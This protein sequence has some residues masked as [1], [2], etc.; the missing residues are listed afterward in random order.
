MQKGT[1]IERIEHNRHNSRHALIDDAGQPRGPA[2]LRGASDNELLRRRRVRELR[3]GGL[4]NVH[5]LDRR[6]GHRQLQDPLGLR[7]DWILHEMPPGE[8]DRAVLT[9]AV[10]AHRVARERDRLVGNLE[11]DCGNA[12]GLLGEDGDDN[13]LLVQLLDRAA[14]IVA[15]SNVQQRAVARGA[16]EIVGNND[17]QLVRPHGLRRVGRGQPLLRRKVEHVALVAAECA[18]EAGT[19]VV[20]REQRLGARNV[21][22]LDAETCLTEARANAENDETGAAWRMKCNTIGFFSFS[23]QKSAAQMWNCFNDEPAAWHARRQEARRRLAQISTSSMMLRGWLRR[24]RSIGIAPPESKT[25]ARRHRA[26][27]RLGRTQKNSNHSHITVGVQF[28]STHERFMSCS[29]MAP[30]LLLIV[31]ALVAVASATA[32]W[33][34]HAADASDA[35]A[36][37]FVTVKGTSFMLQSQPLR[38]SGTNN[39]YLMYSSKTEI[40]DVL[41]RALANGFLTIRM[42]TFLDIGLPP[43]DGAAAGMYL[44]FFNKTANRPAYHEA[45]FARIGACN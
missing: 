6:L 38:F 17:H 15:A 45:D 30:R 23:H 26:R 20:P 10:R 1:Q 7:V 36:G 5:R 13:D 24:R 37:Q 31:C 44:Q 29:V 41:L 22:V 28:I 27:R 43:A 25:G 16:V 14:R 42:W 3:H 39:Y 18:A 21:V 40:D 34:L 32:P 8:R 12:L 11:Q 19:R 9:A 33:P 35:T 4:E 2:A